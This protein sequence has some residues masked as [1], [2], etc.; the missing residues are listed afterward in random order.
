MRSTNAGARL[1]RPSAG[2]AR[3]TLDEAHSSTRLFSGPSRQH[4]ER[5]DQ[6]SVGLTRRPA[7][8]CSIAHSFSDRPEEAKA[9]DSASLRGA[10]G[11]D[12][13]D[14]VRAHLE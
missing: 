13:F 9:P 14:A 8:A 6:H 1:I 11:I 7:H 3:L 4:A 12:E 2:I 10:I 5:R